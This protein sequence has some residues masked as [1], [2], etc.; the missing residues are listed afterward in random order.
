MNW[1]SDVDISYYIYT[2]TERA[3]NA[4]SDPDAVEEYL[5]Y[6]CERLESRSSTSH[7]LDLLHRVFSS[8]GNT[9]KENEFYRMV[10]R[11]LKG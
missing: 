4:K 7:A 6:V 10:E 3:R 11:I 8:D 9:E 5:K 2:A 1:K